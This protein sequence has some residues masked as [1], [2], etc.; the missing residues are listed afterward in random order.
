MPRQIDTVE[1]RSIPVYPAIQVKQVSSYD[2]RASVILR[3]IYLVIVITVIVI[4]INGL[5]HP[6][7]SAMTLTTL[8]HNETW[9]LLVL[10]GICL[11]IIFQ[12][13]RGD[14]APVVASIAFS[15][16]AFALTYA[17]IRWLGAAF[18]RV[19]LKGKD[20]S[21]VRKT[22]MCVFPLPSDLPALRRIRC[23]EKYPSFRG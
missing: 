16:L 3:I 5:P 1:V 6:Q 2:A 13:L 23:T 7:Q 11:A 19:G 12:T 17:L 18:M 4:V 22:E 9:S 20:M 10:S 14:G 8:S 15:G 21:K